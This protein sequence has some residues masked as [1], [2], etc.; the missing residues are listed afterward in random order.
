VSPAT[1]EQIARQTIDANLRAAGWT[2]PDRA[3]PLEQDYA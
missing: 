1:P 3:K 2:V